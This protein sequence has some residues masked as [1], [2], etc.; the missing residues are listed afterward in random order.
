LYEK[1]VENW[2][3]NTLKYRIYGILTRFT[4]KMYWD[5]GDCP[6]RPGI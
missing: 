2:K 5:W 1:N 4:M 3:E 6:P